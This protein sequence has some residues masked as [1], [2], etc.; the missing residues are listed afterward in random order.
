MK[1][2][3]INYSFS[4]D[5]Y[6]AAVLAKR[7]CTFLKPIEAIEKTLPKEFSEEIATIFQSCLSEKAVD[8]P[9][10]A[11]LVINPL[12]KQFISLPIYRERLDG[13]LTENGI[14]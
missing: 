3:E 13:Q 9:V 12:F 7:A 1:N 2:A 6:S 8:R 5:V 14:E 11:E 4:I 10:L